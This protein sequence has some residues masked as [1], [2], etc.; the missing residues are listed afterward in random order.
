MIFILPP[1]LSW[2]YFS[3]LDSHCIHWSKLSLR[4]RQPPRLQ[5]TNHTIFSQEIRVL[6][7]KH[8][9]IILWILPSY[10]YGQD[11]FKIYLDHPIW[12]QDERV[13]GADPARTGLAGSQTSQA[14]LRKFFKCKIWLHHCIPLIELWSKTY[15][16]HFIWSSEQINIIF[17]RMTRALPC[18]TSLAG[19]AAPEPASRFAYAPPW[20]APAPTPAR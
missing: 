17:G 1:W 14:C 16:V 12:S 7:T 13:G 9:Q 20:L 4:T 11:G 2:L 6:T 18:R 10:F 8:G 3:F 19:F 15:M 5:V